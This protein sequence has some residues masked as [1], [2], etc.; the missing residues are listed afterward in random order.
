MADMH[1][2][3]VY[4]GIQ[5]LFASCLLSFKILLLSIIFRLNQVRV[6][7]IMILHGILPTLEIVQSDKMM[8]MV[9]PP[10]RLNHRAI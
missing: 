6:V 10:H 1:S 7:I 2:I 9:V 5:I 4:D 8:E 3:I